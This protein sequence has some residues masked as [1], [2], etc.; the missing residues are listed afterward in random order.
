MDYFRL[1]VYRYDS[2]LFTYHPC[3]S[4]LGGCLFLRLLLTVDNNIPGDKRVT[5]V[6]CHVGL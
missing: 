6:I 5:S 1:V 3:Q 2:S 4:C